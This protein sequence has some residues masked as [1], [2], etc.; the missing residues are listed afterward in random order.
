[1]SI[2]SNLACWNSSLPGGTSTVPGWSES[3]R[4][5]WAT[6]ATKPC[7]S[8]TEVLIEQAQQYLLTVSI[9]SIAGSVCFIYFADRLPRRLWLA[10]SFLVL[11]VLFMATGCVYYGVAHTPGAPATVTLVAIC[12]FAFNFGANT[13][14]FIIPAEIFPTCYRCTCHGISAAA[15]KIGSLVAVLVV[16]GINTAS[17]RSR[18]SSVVRNRQGLIFILFGAILLFGALYAW[19][20]LPD[21]QRRV[22]SSPSSGDPGAPRR[23]P[24]LESKTLEELGEGRERARLEGEILTVRDKVRE[25]R[26]RR[27]ERSR[28]FDPHAH[29][30]LPGRIAP[31][32]EGSRYLHPHPHPQMQ[33]QMQM[34]PQVPPYQYAPYPLAVTTGRAYQGGGAGDP[35]TGTGGQQ[36]NI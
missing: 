5:S 1:M 28:H 14:T 34:Q 15:G 26:R 13:L 18:D 12:H 16:Y 9:S 29:S 21:P 35:Y 31:Q 24:R 11:A 22:P 10:V 23:R 27:R 25:F 32:D 3:G 19:A 30:P 4:P 36:P 33:M 7:Q 17:R 6:D 8:I 2:D 20:Y